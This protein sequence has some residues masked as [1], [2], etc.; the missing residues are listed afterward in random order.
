MNKFNKRTINNNNNNTNLS[1]EKSM[2][3]YN[4][5]KILDYL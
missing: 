2:D 1:M 4:F 3:K 5:K